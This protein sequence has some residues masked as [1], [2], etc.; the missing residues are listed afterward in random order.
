[1]SVPRAISCSDFQ[2]KQQPV[3][4]VCPVYRGVDVLISEVDST[5][6]S[7]LP[8]T[9]EHATGCNK[10]VARLLQRSYNIVTTCMLHATKYIVVGLVSVWL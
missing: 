9:I 3:G 5:L 4:S 10:V 6:A 1:M 2:Q 7:T 8:R